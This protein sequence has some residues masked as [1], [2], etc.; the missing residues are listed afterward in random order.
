MT[1]KLLISQLKDGENLFSF[2]SEKDAWVN[3]LSQHFSKEVSPLEGPL[4]ANISL[5]KLEPD[6][7]LKGQLEFRTRRTCSRCAEAFSLPVTHPFD[8]AMVHGSAPDAPK[9]ETESEGDVFR[10][11]GPEIDI[12][13]L[14]QEQAVLS[15]P[16]APL[17]KPDC[18]GICQEC[19]WNLNQSDCGCKKPP[20]LNPFSVLK[21]L[22]H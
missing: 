14:L 7:Y 10:F 4:N 1:V 13:P 19:G 21:N 11:K 20:A 22:I 6:Y 15:L 8:L 17:C 5:T 16:F 12:A 3:A 18:R 2:S 9:F